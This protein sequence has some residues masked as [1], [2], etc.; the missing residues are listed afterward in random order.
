MTLW[1]N[2]TYKI[3][4]TNSKLHY[5]IGVNVVV[6]LLI[7]LFPAIGSYLLL[8]HDIQALLTRFWTPLTFI[9][10][11]GGFFNILFNMLW[12]Y[13]IGNVFEDLLGR[14]RIIGLYLLGGLAG[15]LFFIVYTN[16]LPAITTLSISVQSAIPGGTAAL[17]AILVATATLV[18]NQKIKL[19]LIGEVKLKWLIAAYILIDLISVNSLNAGE[20]VAHIGGAMAGFAYIKQLRQSNPWTSIISKLFK[21]RSKLKVV[22]NNPE[23]NSSA[24]PRQEEIDRILDKISQSGYENLTRQE[25]E[26]LFRASKDEG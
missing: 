11:H 21:R 3:Q 10:I 17:M 18:P 26:I 5:L 14:K 4:R 12:L 16:V 13:W 2:I 22:S 9:F 25:K 7:S 6:W 1:E 24:K 8:S 15:A 23:K 20:K 19:I